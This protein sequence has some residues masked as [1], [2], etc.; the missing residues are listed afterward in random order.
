MHRFLISLTSMVSMLMMPCTKIWL[1]YPK[2]SFAQLFWN[3]QLKTAGTKHARQVCW[4]PLIIRWCMNLKL[5]LSS[6][7]HAMATSRFLRLPTERTLRDY[8]NYSKAQSG[9]QVE[10]DCHLQKEV[11]YQK[12]KGFVLSSMK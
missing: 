8:T 2:G 7:Y 1:T 9:Y 6:A 3:E 5:I 4:H 10:V 11:L 12:V